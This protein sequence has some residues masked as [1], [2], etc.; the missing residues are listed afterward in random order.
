VARDRVYLATV[1][2]CATRKI[3]GWTM[4]DNYKTPLI[5]RAIRMAAR[6]VPLPAD[7]IFHSDRG[8]NYT[9]GEFAGVLAELGIRQS[10]GR[11]G[12]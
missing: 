4:D 5:A 10:V 7:A 11:T 1:I 8:S 6:N 2:D 9:S 3:I 12:I